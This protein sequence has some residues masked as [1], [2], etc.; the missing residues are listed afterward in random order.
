MRLI[1][2]D[3]LII[4]LYN[5]ERFEDEDMLF[6]YEDV[7]KIIRD[8][9]TINQSELIDGLKKSVHTNGDRIRNMTDEA[10]VGIVFKKVCEIIRPDGDCKGVYF[11][12]CEKCVLQWLKQEVSEDAGTD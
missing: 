8:A 5:I 3:A 12:N 7:K 4:F 6:T 1:D 9:P 2:A 10:L 11:G